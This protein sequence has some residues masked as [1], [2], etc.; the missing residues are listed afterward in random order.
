MNN[1]EIANDQ[2]IPLFMKGKFKFKSDA[3]MLSDCK[4]TFIFSV[5]S[6]YRQFYDHKVPKTL[7]DHLE[8]SSV[9]INIKKKVFKIPPIIKVQIDK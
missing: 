6:A 1:F 4:R 8:R 7:K 3:Y 2:N 9:R 5:F